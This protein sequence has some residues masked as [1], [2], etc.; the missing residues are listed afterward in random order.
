MKL[1][2]KTGLHAHNVFLC[3]AVKLNFLIKSCTH[4]MV[5]GSAT[6]LA[7]MLIKSSSH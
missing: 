2:F 3:N 1:N 5:L 7:N 4:S 6:E